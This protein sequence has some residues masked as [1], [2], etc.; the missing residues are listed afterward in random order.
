MDDWNHSEILAMM[1]GGNKQL[2][3]FFERHALSEQSNSSS[4]S[5]RLL[6]SNKE[7]VTRRRYKTYAAQFYRNKL[8][9]H[10]QNV[11]NRGIYQG[12]E[13]WRSPIKKTN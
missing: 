2:S 6:L 11:S 5:N 12:R 7:K 4:I 1:E 3:D 9:E 8:T 10:V 13:V